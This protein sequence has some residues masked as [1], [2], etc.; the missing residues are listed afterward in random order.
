MFFLTTEKCFNEHDLI[1]LFHS[2][3]WETDTPSSVLYVAMQNASNIVT[4]W[5]D[6]KLIGLIRSMDDSVWN[7]NID[8]L[9]VHKEY[10]HRGVGASLVDEL[11][12]NLG[13]ILCISVSPS[14]KANNSFYQKFGFKE[15]YGSSL[16]QIYN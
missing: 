1:E 6:E 7:A 5:S 11:L 12:R 13:H 3:D 9:V 8:C 10:Q 14:E 16:L 4:A 2:V 15:I